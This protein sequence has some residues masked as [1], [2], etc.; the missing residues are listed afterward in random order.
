MIF[1]YLALIEDWIK[2]QS[3]HKFG[4]KW[5][6]LG[7]VE[8]YIV[9]IYLLISYKNVITLYRDKLISSSM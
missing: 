2:F 9:L 7:E 8:Y 1:K 4:T 5:T 3:F 6:N